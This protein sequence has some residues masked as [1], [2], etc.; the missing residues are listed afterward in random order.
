MLVPAYNE[1]AAIVESV[2]SLLAL[3]YPRFEVV[4]VNDGSTRRDARRA[5]RGVRPR[6]GAQGAARHARDRSRSAASTA[7]AATA[8]CWSSTRRTAARPTPS[9]PASTPRATLRLRHRRRRADRGGRAAAASCEPILDDPRDRR[10]AA[11]IVR[12]A[13]GCRDRA[14]A[15]S[16]RSRCRATALATIQIVE[17]FRAFLVG[18][19][20]WSACRRAA[21]HL[22]RVRPVPPLRRRWRSAAT[23]PTTVGEDMEL[24]VRLHRHLR[25]RGEAVPDRVRPRPGLL[26]RGARELRDARAPAPPLAA[27]ARR[28]ALAPPRHGVQ[29]ALRRVGMFAMPYFVR[30]RA[31]RP[32]GRGAR[33]PT[34]RSRG[35]RWAGV[36]TPWFV[37]FLGRGGAARQRCCRSAA[38]ALEEFAFRRHPRAPRRAAAGRFAV[39][40][41]F[42]YRQLVALWRVLAFVDLP[43]AATRLGRD[44]KRRG[45]AQ[46]ERVG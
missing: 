24:V 2:R 9:T 23:G 26:D 5:A 11:A 25:D 14:T 46:S 41:N 32:A 29:P 12:I 13:N 30:L 31:A 36:S 3:R 1:E 37:A 6:A 8:T 34:S 44:P 27:R 21:D 20:G 35:R 45:F 43:A 40:E 10:R 18:R 17:Y 42:G 38:L 33:L 16:R 15:A 7:R 28:D 22:R 39:V 4:V 19:V